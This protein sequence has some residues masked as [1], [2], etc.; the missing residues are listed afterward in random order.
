VV[1]R[2]NGVSGCPI[3]TTCLIRNSLDTPIL[4]R[5][6]EN[7]CPLTSTWVCASGSQNNL[8][9]K[10]EAK[11]QTSNLLWESKSDKKLLRFPLAFSEFFLFTFKIH[12]Y[13]FS[14]WT[15]I[16]CL[17]LHSVFSISLWFFRKTWNW[18]QIKYNLTFKQFFAFRLF[19]FIIYPLYLNMKYSYWF[20]CF[21]IFMVKI[22]GLL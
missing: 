2:V 7:Q 8:N 15:Y 18:K 22:T 12:F 19:L 14:L 17:I 9:P 16:N 4:S 10:L 13:Y 5:F 11:T 1:Y 6:A 20:V 21:E 3:F